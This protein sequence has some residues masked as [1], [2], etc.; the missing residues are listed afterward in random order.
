MSAELVD[1]ASLPSPEN[2]AREEEV[3]PEAT[4]LKSDVENGTGDDRLEPG[5]F[6]SLPFHERVTMGATR[7]RS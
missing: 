3:K 6:R 4:G 5:D 7:L 1:A 2:G